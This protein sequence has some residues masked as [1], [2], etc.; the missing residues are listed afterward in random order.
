MAQQK[1][2]IAQMLAL[3][4][5]V[6]LLAALT[7][8]IFASSSKPVN[9]CGSSSSANNSTIPIID[10]DNCNLQ[11]DV[12]SLV[13]Q[14]ASF[15]QS[16]HIIIVQAI[17]ACCL[18]SF[19]PAL[20]AMEWTRLESRTTMATLQT[21][22]ELTQAPGLATAFFH[23]VTS[24]SPS[25]R[26]FFVFL[27]AI[28]SILSPVAVSPIYRS[29]KGP[30]PTSADLVVGGG[31]GPATS[32][33][34]SIRSAVP[35]GVVA[36]RALLNAGTSVKSEAP[37][38]TFD[39]NAAPFLHRD[40]VQ[41][42]WSATV[43]TVVAYNSIDCG[44]TAPTR[45]VPSGGDIVSFDTSSFFSH[46]Y[47]TVTPSIAGRTFG[48]MSNDP[49]ITAVYLNSSVSSEL[50]VVS[51]TTSL[52]FLA[53]NGTL[54]GAQQTI[55]STLAKA[56]VDFVNVLVC[57]S[58]TK[59]IKS[60]CTINQGNVT[61][62]NPIPS[63]DLPS[64]ASKTGTLETHIHNPNSVA[65]TLS[66]SPSTA[67]YT[68]YEFLPMYAKITPDL[69]ASDIPP[70]S[71]LT[72]EATGDHYYLPLTYIQN[73]LF[74]Q[75]SQALVQGMVTK[76]SVTH[77]TEFDLWA[78]F[79]IS[80]APLLYLILGL[81]TICAIA[82]TLWSSLPASSRHATKMD[83]ARLVAISRNPNLDA[84]FLR[85]ADRK[86]EI[87]NEVLDSRVR[88]AW[89]EQLGRS[90]LVVE[91]ELGPPVDAGEKWMNPGAWRTGEQDLQPLMWR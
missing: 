58:T 34:F 27:V 82:S 21:G 55:T 60:S 61:Q 31:V 83:V 52:V 4:L 48:L 17:A 12:A 49:Q 90:A 85:Y 87:Q 63:S 75:T 59:L 28:L 19:K 30:Y 7:G 69:I 38:I 13:Y 70:F 68:A 86:V 36:G 45:I 78:T 62:C 6:G 25:M 37:L 56:R 77:E 64:S 46:N 20:L 11:S 79:S 39:V 81:S 26:T 40:T 23:A 84:T 74:G 8:L 91:N 24:K 67:Y 72:F 89:V 9:S 29:H 2:F 53:T 5:A 65:M 1:I 47:T 73:A 42:I 66:A 14:H 3:W 18:A 54:E 71:Y 41:A 76:W 43:S 15:F 57:T 33:S 16:I 50:G 51:A 44:P 22:I 88:Y 35:D 80:H 10:P 32:A